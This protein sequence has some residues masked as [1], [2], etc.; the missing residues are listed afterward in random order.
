M[1]VNSKVALFISLFI[2]VSNNTARESSDML[3]K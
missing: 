3:L 1:G 2:V